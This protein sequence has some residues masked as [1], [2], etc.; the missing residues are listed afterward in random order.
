MERVICV[1][2]GRNYADREA[3]F[4]ALDS[5]NDP[6]IDWVVHGFAKGA[7]SLAREWAISRGVNHKG[8]PADWRVH[9]PK[10]GPLRNKQ[11]LKES[12]PTL[13]VWFPGGPGT[14]NCVA[15]AERM[16]ILVLRGDTL[17]I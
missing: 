4:R 12:N 16:G 1:T 17:D 7:D 8:Y 6:I 5:L 10:A 14:K 9:G 2:G 3:V 13:L 11:M 15:T